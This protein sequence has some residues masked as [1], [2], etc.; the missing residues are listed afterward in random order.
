[1]KSA[2]AYAAVF[3]AVPLLLAACAQPGTSSPAGTPTP[4]TLIPAATC[5]PPS[6]GPPPIPAFLDYPPSGS[7]NVSISIGEIIEKGAGVPGG[8]PA[9]I[10]IT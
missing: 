10:T 7:T 5:P 2:A 1:M 9:P 3:V 8:A 4:R 6:P